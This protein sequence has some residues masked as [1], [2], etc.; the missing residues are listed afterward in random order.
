MKKTDR[1]VKRTQKLLKDALAKLL[2]DNELH[3]ISIS[4]LTDL[5][6]VSRGAFYSHYQDIFDLYEQMENEFM[7]DLNSLIDKNPSDLY[8]VVYKQIVD[9]VYDN[10]DICRIFI[11]SA[12]YRDKLSS[13]LEKRYCEIIKR[14][15][16]SAEIKEDWKYI[17]SYHCEGFIAALR[18][19]LESNFTY[20]KEKLLKMY[21][22]IDNATDF[23]YV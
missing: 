21:V 2:M 20:P 9:Y 16:N 3:K 17:I 13:M 14:E 15:T 7:R 10:A 6:D 5:A 11:C 18:L 8:E 22:D 4:K 1:R 12:R 19:W 23:L